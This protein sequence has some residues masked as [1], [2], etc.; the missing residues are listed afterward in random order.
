MLM[1]VNFPQ[2][3]ISA[4]ALEWEGR[5]IM[6]CFFLLFLRVHSFSIFFIKREY[7]YFLC[8]CIS[9]LVNH[10]L[11]QSYRKWLILFYCK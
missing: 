3:S 8:H 5:H 2:R 4:T 9:D 11:S 7:L 6:I 1:L 10:R